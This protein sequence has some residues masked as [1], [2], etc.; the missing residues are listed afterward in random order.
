MMKRLLVQIPIWLW[1]FILCITEISILPKLL[2]YTYVY[3]PPAIFPF[4]ILLSSSIHISNAVTDNDGNYSPLKYLWFRVLG[5]TVFILVIYISRHEPFDKLI[6]I[7]IRIFLSGIG[8]RIIEKY[9]TF[10]YDYLR[11]NKKS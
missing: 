8:Y 4:G 10:R 6:T 1:I 2:D 3:A 11:N 9:A 5:A 7:T